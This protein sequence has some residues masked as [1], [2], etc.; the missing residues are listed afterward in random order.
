MMKYV[1]GT[2]KRS[3]TFMIHGY[4]DGLEGSAFDSLLANESAS[5]TMGQILETIDLLGLDN[6]R[7]S[8][9]KKRIKN[10]YWEQIG[11]LLSAARRIAEIGFREDCERGR[12]EVDSPS[13]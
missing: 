1:L 3:D 10:L 6:E 12:Y 8:L 2:D 11:E 9:A 4:Q 13:K 5:L 7:S